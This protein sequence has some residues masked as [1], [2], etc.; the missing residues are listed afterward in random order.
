VVGLARP[1]SWP[2]RGRRAAPRHTGS[3]PALPGVAALIYGFT[4]VARKGGFAQ[5]AVLAPITLGVVL[6]VAF[7]LHA[8][9]SREPLI[10]LRLFGKRSFAAASSLLFLSGFAL[11]GAL[12]LMPLYYQQLRGQSALVAGCCWSLKEPERC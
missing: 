12:L 1:A 4:E 3:G 5:G 6:L 7:V 10:D 2:G 9:R 11:Y 8:L